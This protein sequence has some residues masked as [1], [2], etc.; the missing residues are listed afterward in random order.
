MEQGLGVEGRL[1]SRLNL[2]SRR[3]EVRPGQAPV[4]RPS[5]PIG[6]ASAGTTGGSGQLRLGR[7]RVARDGTAVAP[8]IRIRR[9]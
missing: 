9:V 5:G 7:D 1:L 3:G 4:D 8:R 2:A 6:P